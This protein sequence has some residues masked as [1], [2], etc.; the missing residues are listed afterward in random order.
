VAGRTSRIE[1]L[2]QMSEEHEQEMKDLVRKWQAYL[3]TLPKP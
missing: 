1:K 2:V 3:R